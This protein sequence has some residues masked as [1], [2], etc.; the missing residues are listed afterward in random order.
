MGTDTRRAGAVA[1]WVLFAGALIFIVGVLDIIQGLVALF[2]QEVYAVG[3]SGLILTTNFSTWGW[4]LLIWGI[5]M[6]L[7]AFSLFAGAGFG[8]WF[9]V[10]VVT[11]NM[12]GQFAWFPAYPL[13][14][15]VA[16]GLSVAVLWA[17]T[18]GWS[19]LAE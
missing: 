8:R 4:M 3:E 2:K 18:A 6:V 14:S 13:W 12:I 1:G 19:E 16:I 15:M 9:A 5:V 10:I 7:A 11:V 17:L